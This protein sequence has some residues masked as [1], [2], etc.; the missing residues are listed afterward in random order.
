M[1]DE[2]KKLHQQLEEMEAN[3]VKRLAINTAVSSA[4]VGWHIEHS[5]LVINAIIESLKQSDPKL[6]K[7]KFN[8]KKTVIFTLGK[9]PRGRG[10]A[11]KVV[12]PS[13]QLDTIQTLE[14]LE[15]TKLAVAELANLNKG[16]FFRHPIFG[17]LRLR[18]SIRFLKIHTEHHLRIVRDIIGGKG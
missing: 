12:N 3:V 9:L 13:E 7:R 6:F 8:L 2:I 4:S 18:N 17:H 14:H 16:V 11:P 15:K 5:M 1:N 10:K